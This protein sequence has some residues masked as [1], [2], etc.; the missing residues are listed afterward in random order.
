MEKFA[1]PLHPM[2]RSDVD[3][4]ISMLKSLT[5]H[6]LIQLMVDRLGNYNM[7]VLMPL[8]PM[9]HFTEV[10]FTRGQQRA[11]WSMRLKWQLNLLQSFPV[12]SP[13]NILTAMKDFTI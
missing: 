9:L 8:L 2:K 1:S 10:A 6:M 3:Q 13:L 11:R 4:N 12:N 5:R 7:K